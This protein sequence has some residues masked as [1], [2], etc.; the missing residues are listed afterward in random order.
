MT[1][2]ILASTVLTV[3]IMTHSYTYNPPVLYTSDYILTFCLALHLAPCRQCQYLV[4]TFD[5]RSLSWLLAANCRSLFG[6]L[7][8]DLCLLA[9]MYPVVGCSGVA[10]FLPSRLDREHIASD[11]ATLCNSCD[12]CMYHTPMSSMF[13]TVIQWTALYPCR[14]CQYLVWTFDA[15]SLSWLL[16]AN[17]RSLFG[18]L[19]L[20]LCLLALMYPV[21][22][23]SGVAHFL[24]SRL[25]REHIASDFATLCSSCD[26]C[27][28]HTPM[29]SI[30]NV[31]NCHSMDGLIQIAHWGPSM[32]SL[33]SSRTFTLLALAE[34]LIIRGGFIGVPSVLARGCPCLP[35]IDWLCTQCHPHMASCYS[36]MLSGTLH[37]KAMVLTMPLHQRPVVLVCTD[38]NGQV[39]FAHWPYPKPKSSLVLC[40][41]WS[42][43]A[44][45]RPQLRAL[46]VQT[47]LKSSVGPVSSSEASISVKK[48]WPNGP[49]NVRTV[50]RSL[51]IILPLLWQ[52]SRLIVQRANLLH[53]SVARHDIR[54]P[55]C[56]LRSREV[57][58]NP[59]QDVFPEEWE[60]VDGKARGTAHHVVCDLVCSRRLSSCLSGCLPLLCLCTCTTDP[61]CSGNDSRCCALSCLSIHDPSP[62]GGRGELVPA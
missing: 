5:A 10:H 32:V 6:P 51:N 9:L 8:L 40:L 13:I 31:H 15:R 14:Q 11:F 4:W 29:S 46:V 45:L 52:V 34:C 20:D 16:A 25:D 17:C 43:A 26:L 39:S 1:F 59:S 55:M 18:P 24:P 33:R 7:R 36:I 58:A 12:L 50:C 62:V 42:D 30:I 57:N 28:Y 3:L 37:V 48:T 54:E 23:C 49:G 44:F 27:M 38:P 53:L 19:R 60:N 61:P 35:S 56:P 41:N 2:T 47:S 22:G 21:V